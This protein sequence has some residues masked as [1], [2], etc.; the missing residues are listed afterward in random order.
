MPRIRYLKQNDLD[1]RN[2]V[3]ELFGV[4]LEGIRT[5]RSY[6]CVD[7]FKNKLMKRV[8]DSLQVS[9]N[10]IVVFRCLNLT[11]AICIGFC[12]GINAILLV[13]FVDKDDP[14]L[15]SLSLS[16]TSTIMQL[17][18]FM[19][20][21]ML[22]TEIFM[23]STERV[24]QFRCLYPEEDSEKN[25][26]QINDGKIEFRNVTMRYNENMEFVLK[27][28]TFEV[29]GGQHIGVI[30]RT[31]SGKSTLL[32]VLL[33][34]YPIQN[35][36]IYIDGID[37]TT[38]S[39]QSLRTKISIIP[40]SPFIFTETLRNNLDPLNCHTDQEIID[41]LEA[42][43][44]QHFFNC[45]KG[46]DTHL[47]RS[48]AM[49]AGQ[50]QLICLCRAILKQSKILVIDEATAFTD[51]HTDE[52]IQSTIN[53]YFKSSTILT[54]AHRLATIMDYDRMIL[55]D[56]GEIMKI[57]TPNEM[58]E[59]RRITMTPN[60][61]SRSDHEFALR[62]QYES[63]TNRSPM[64]TPMH[65]SAGATFGSPL[66]KQQPLSLVGN[67]VPVRTRYTSYSSYSPF[68]FSR[69]K[70]NFDGESTLRSYYESVTGV[71][72]KSLKRVESRDL[73]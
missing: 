2:H 25:E 40:Q 8:S 34:L 17:L 72:I 55:M 65:D 21:T 63:L 60:D 32:Q 33:R 68:K 29:N 5:I 46:L 6:N 30:G 11:S 39:L 4:T 51:F 20:K 35:G 48:F 28:V 24:N 50:K 59:K 66:L 26:L 53:E 12:L 22:D 41:A 38:I 54:V 10:F 67:H 45:N 31:G 69:I 57:G 27:D 42:V 7:Y 70:T 13:I 15:T 19:I 14:G 9:F 61:K 49:S 73:Q 3:N 47:S 71:I 44:L 23:S 58:V 18:P 36:T 43:S 37:I 1:C 56:G 64:M 62:P 16:F 52:L